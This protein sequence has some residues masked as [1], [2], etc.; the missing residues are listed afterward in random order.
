M[1]LLICVTFIALKKATIELD[2]SQWPLVV[3]RFTGAP[4]D[5]EFE[6]YLRLYE[7]YLERTGRYGLVLVTEPDAPMTKSKHAKMQA[8]WIKDHFEILGRKCV[9]ISFVLPG[10]MMRGVLKAILAMQKLPMDHTVF[11]R[12]FDACQ[13]IRDR[14]HADRRRSAAG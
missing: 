3:I 5:E 4:T 13:W 2:D 14:I 10:P 1:F 9:G 11:A 8:Q 7:S 6:E 12:E